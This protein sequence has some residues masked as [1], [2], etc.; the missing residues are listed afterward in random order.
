MMETHKPLVA[1][2]GD[3][4]LTRYEGSTIEVVAGHAANVAVRLSH[5]GMESVYIGVVGA[6]RDGDAV[7]NGLAAE[8]VDVSHLVVG[9][10]TTSVAVLRPIGDEQEIVNADPGVAA[11]LRLNGAQ[12]PLLLECTWVHCAGLSEAD[13]GALTLLAAEGVSLSYDFGDRWTEKLVGTFAPHLE[14]AFFNGRDL[15]EDEARRHVQRV[16]ASGARCAIATRGRYGVVAWA[17]GRLFERAARHVMIVDALGAGDAFIAGFIVSTL[18]GGAADEAIERGLGEATAACAH[19][20][21]W[22]PRGE[23]IFH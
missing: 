23:R 7:R 12:V 9:D 11:S 17:E 20:G 1:C 22:R 2:V 21:A 16:V 10:G 13:A 19:F 8:G 18:A 14:V 5:A 15:S 6:D 4:C 3:N